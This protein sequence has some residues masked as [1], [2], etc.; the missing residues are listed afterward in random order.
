[1][2]TIL[3]AG[4]KGTR[5]SEET[6]RIPKP[7][8]TIGGYPI[9]WHIMQ[10]YA[11]HGFREF[12]VALGYK[13]NLIKRY[14][15]EYHQLAGNMHIDLGK[16]QIKTDGN[17]APDWCIDLIDTGPDTMTAGR[18]RRL[19][20]WLDN[21][22][23]MVTYGDGVA[24]IDLQ[25]LVA[26]HRSHDKLATVTAVRPPARFGLMRFDGDQVTDF[27]EKPQT[28]QGWIN[29]GFFVFQPE[30]GDYIFGSDDM[31]LERDPLSRLAQDGQLMAYKHPG[32]W[33]PMDTLRDRQLL[34][35]MWQRNDARW[36][37]WG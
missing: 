18:L 17:E 31:M 12:C 35:A 30:A 23:F 34:E 36:R 26:F 37:L 11:H 9:L 10:I 2:K 14:F 7:L 33:Q 3:L 20:P 21:Q 24:D 28:E 8:V 1:M 13:G 15:A 19:Q 25:Q 22:P 5:L 6:Q 4:G 27:A 16:G 29:G 32:F